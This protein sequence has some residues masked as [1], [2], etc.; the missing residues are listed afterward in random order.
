[1]RPRLVASK[2]PT[3]CLIRLDAP[4]WTPRIRCQITTDRLGT[5]GHT[6]LIQNRQGLQPKKAG[7]PLDTLPCMWC[8]VQDAPLLVDSG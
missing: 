8:M 6:G 4:H 3:V 1:M 2:Y 5:A 7:N